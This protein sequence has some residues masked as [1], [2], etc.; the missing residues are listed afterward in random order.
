MENSIYVG[1]T[2]QVALQDKMDIIAN[3]IANMSTPGYRAQNMVF[4]EF[5]EKAP[6]KPDTAENDPLSMVLNYGHYQNTAPGPM[7]MTGNQLDVAVQGPGYLGVQAAGEEVM[8]TRAGNFQIN[9]EGTLVTGA[10]LPVANEGGAPIVIPDD[11]K[12]I[13]IGE[14][15]TIATEEG[16]IAKLMVVEF[17][18]AQDL[19]AMGNGL[20]KSEEPG[21]PAEGTRVMQGMIEGSNVNPVLEMTR[22]IDTARAYQSTQRMLQSEHE[23]QRSMI[24]RLTGSR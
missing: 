1:L 21:L 6:R 7:E 8:Y 17:P 11:A 10:G 18:N 16:E 14:D 15:G 24:Q 20:Y 13:Y 5:I 3:N 19:E 23:R 9:V 22:M 12:E 4:T 2:R